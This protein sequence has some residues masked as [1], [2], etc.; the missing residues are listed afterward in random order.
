MKDEMQE[1]VKERGFLYPAEKTR[2]KAIDKMIK[3][4]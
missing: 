2:I 1:V 4:E 3:H